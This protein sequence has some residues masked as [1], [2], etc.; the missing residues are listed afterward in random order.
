[1]LHLDIF[2]QS[3]KVCTSDMFCQMMKCVLGLI[4][5]CETLNSI[6]YTYINK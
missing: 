2:V 5:H 1:M 3:N 6:P 4:M